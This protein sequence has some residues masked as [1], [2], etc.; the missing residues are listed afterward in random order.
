MPVRWIPGEHFFAN[1]Y[2]Y[3]SVLVD[4]GVLP[5][6][7][8]DHASD[9]DTIVL[10][11]CHYDH[12]AYVAEIATMCEADV[13]IHSDDAAALHDDARS[14]SLLFGA[15]IPPFVP[16]RLLSE[17]DLIGGLKVLHTP[18]HTPGSICLYNEEDHILFSGDT[19]FSGGGF[20]R[21]DF[22][23]GSI[24]QLKQSVLR[25]RD[26]DVEGLYP[27]HG[28]PV[29]RAGSRHIDAAWQILQS[30]YG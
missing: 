10:T 4:A 29:L 24:S 20:G 17:G 13:C 3:G 14:L 28:E 11:H 9:I 22:P 21:V 18:G 16:T 26:L 23:G 1:S 7:L 5:M 6:T 15:R 19:V 27:G 8:A 30:A 12:I 25:L 2:Q